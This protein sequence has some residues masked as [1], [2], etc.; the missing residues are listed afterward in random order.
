MKQIE[1]KSVVKYGVVGFAILGVFGIASTAWSA[2]GGSIELMCRNKAKEI[3]AET[4]KNCVTDVKQSQVRS[5]RKEYED[6]LAALKSHYDGELKKISNGQTATK[7]AVSSDDQIEV[8]NNRP[9]VKESYIKRSSGARE[10][11]MD[12]NNNESKSELKDTSKDQSKASKLDL[13]NNT[14]A[15]TIEVVE[16]PPEQE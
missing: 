8:Q 15:S 2:Q 7:S 14:D 5:L 12:S 13:S 6:K 9:V 1:L 3:A 4:Y 10:L 16:I 11:P